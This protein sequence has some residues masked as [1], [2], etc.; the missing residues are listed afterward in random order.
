M[1]VWKKLLYL[2]S[3]SPLLFRTLVLLLLI[4]L[5]AVVI[6]PAIIPDTLY[7]RAYL[8]DKA[9]QA[10]EAFLNNESFLIPDSI[11][12]W[13]N[14]P[15]TIKENW[16]V[17]HYGSRS[18]HAF[19]ETATKPLRVIFVGSSMINGGTHIRNDET[20]SAFLEDR[21]IEA[22]NFGTMLFSLDQS[23]LLLEQLLVYKPDV[24]I[25]GLDS[26]PLSGLRN[27]YIPFRNP[28]EVNMP[29][30]K[31]RFLFNKHQLEHISMEPAMLTTM[32]KDTTVLDVLKQYDGYYHRFARYMHMGHTPLA[33]S[34]SYVLRKLE[35][36]QQYQYGD[37]QSEIILLE[38]MKKA[39]A[40]A[41]TRNFKLFFLSMP[42]VSNIDQGQ[43][44]RYFPNWYDRRQQTL[45]T[46]SF[47][48]ID[49][50]QI[51]LN[52]GQEIA[53]L[54]TDDQVHFTPMG[55]QLIADHLR[56]FIK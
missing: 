56:R 8:N 40:L 21:D 19:E 35:S 23:L 2:R 13:R 10:T 49:A 29:F 50:K 38:L 30:L 39:L 27:I 33:G 18:H 14:K 20:I 25:M 15:N 55:N 44:M 45:A 41:E 47:P 43:L 1:P 53:T 5:I 42:S 24:V 36:L 48:V 7:L 9:E 46:L 26:D 51:F 17:D 22:L 28:D 34:L 16:K 4:E 32:L 31:P 12:G 52:S 6:A 54:Y 3:T 37:Q 11:T